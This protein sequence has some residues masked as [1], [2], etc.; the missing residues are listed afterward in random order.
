MTVDYA[1]AN[2]T[3]TAGSDYT[4]ASGTLTFAPGTLT[5]T[6]GVPVLATR[7]TADRD[8]PGEPEHPDERDDRRRPAT[9]TITDDDGAP[10]LSIGDVTVAEGSGTQPSR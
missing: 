9:G 7:S 5:Q 2:G 10:V 3:A 6:L 1:T 8:L 4:A